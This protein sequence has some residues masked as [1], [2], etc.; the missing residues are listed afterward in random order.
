MSR[1][2]K[3]VASVAVSIVG[4]F[5]VMQLIPYG[6]DRSN[7]PVVQEPAWDS[8]RTRELAVRACFDC[9]SNETQWPDYARVAPLSWMVGRD[10][11][12]ARSVLNFS[13]WTRPY[14]LS[15]EA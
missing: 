7:P 5:A 3:I 8:P 1:R 15:S 11:E 9:H 14:E 12:V 13:D 10:V 6:R 4:L 2:L